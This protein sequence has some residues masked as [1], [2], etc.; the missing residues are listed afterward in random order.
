[1]GKL[2]QHILEITILFTLFTHTHTHTHTYMHTHTHTHTQA[3]GEARKVRLPQLSDHF[4]KRD[5][6]LLFRRDQ[7]LEGINLLLPPHA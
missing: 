3:Y 5:V 4:C 7:N 1:M 2:S 6:G